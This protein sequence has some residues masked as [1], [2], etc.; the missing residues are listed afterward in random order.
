MK[1]EDTVQPT[2]VYSAEVKQL[3]RNAFPEDIRDYPD[4]CHKQVSH[5]T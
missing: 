3:I 4:P 5:I 1:E 2:Y